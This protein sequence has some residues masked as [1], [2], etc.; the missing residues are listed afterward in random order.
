MIKYII[1]QRRYFPEYTESTLVV[2]EFTKPVF[3]L[4]DKK[5]PHGVKVAGETCIPECIL[6]VTVN[7]SNRFKKEMI[8][9]YNKPDLSIQ[10]DGIRFDGVR[11][12]GGLTVKDSLGCLLANYINN[13]NGTMSGRASDDL[14]DHIK[15]LIAA[16]HT[17]KWIITS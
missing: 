13:G 14:K 2:P 8:L 3:I 7:M 4:E 5:Q 1:Q 17:V 11:V 16:G 10:K 6:D 12:H 15:K 9:L